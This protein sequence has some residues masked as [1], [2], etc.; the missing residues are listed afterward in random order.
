MGP[1]EEAKRF[2]LHKSLAVNESG[3]FESTFRNDWKESSENVIRLPDR[4]PEAFEM[5]FLFIYTRRI[6]SR[7]ANDLFGNDGPSEWYRLAHAWTLSAYL[8]ATDFQDA[9][10]DAVLEKASL[11]SASLHDIH[12]IIY[13]NSIIGTPV[14]K[15]FVD[16]AVWKW[17]VVSLEAQSNGLSWSDFFRDLSIALLKTRGSTEEARVV[18]YSCDYHEHRLR[19]TICYRAKRH[20][21]S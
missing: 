16:L 7:Q 21:F 14:R 5:F 20:G 9:I 6:Y 19:G 17:D 18:K 1:E 12:K 4:D 3:F 10:A 2:S 13:A 8:Q 15:L 11:K